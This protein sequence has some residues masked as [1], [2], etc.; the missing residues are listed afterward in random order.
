MNHLLV[1]AAV[2]GII[3]F[4]EA[5]ILN[6]Q[7]VKKVRILIAGMERESYAKM[8]QEGARIKIQLAQAITPANEQFSNVIKRALELFDKSVGFWL[9]WVDR[10]PETLEEEKKSTARRV[11]KAWEDVWGS[12]NDPKVIEAIKDTA[13]AI[14]AQAEL[15]RKKMV[16]EAEMDLAARKKRR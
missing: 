16:E 8:Y 5:D 1:Q 3:N 13:G 12:L 10:S 14:R 2:R 9:P 6:P 4:N 15:T 11:A 7:W